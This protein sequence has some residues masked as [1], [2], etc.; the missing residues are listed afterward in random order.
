MINLNILVIIF[1][2]PY[3]STLNLVIWLEVDVEIEF[4]R[5]R[6]L[7]QIAESC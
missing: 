7:P 3:G 1:H 4:H 5:A 2:V 6:K